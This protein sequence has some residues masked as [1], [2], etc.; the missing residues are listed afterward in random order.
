MFT[1]R[2]VANLSRSCG[3][4]SRPSTLMAHAMPAQLTAVLM[5]PNLD[6]RA[7]SADVIC[8]KSGGP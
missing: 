1:M 2:V 7:S 6:S 3:L 8:R 5:T 4:F